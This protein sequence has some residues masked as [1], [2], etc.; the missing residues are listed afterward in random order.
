ASR[1][2]PLQQSVREAQEAA[3]SSP[4]QG[5]L[6]LLDVAL[7]FKIENRNLM[8]AAEDAGLSSPYQAG[9]YSWWHESLR[10]ALAQVPGVHA[11][12]FTAHALLAAIRADLVAY[13]IDDQKMA[14]DAMRSSLATYVDDV[15]GTREEA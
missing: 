6:A 5:V 7:R 8:S 10:G 2:E 4:R 11:P 15:L 1:L 12:D 3:A 14:P 9:H 13:L